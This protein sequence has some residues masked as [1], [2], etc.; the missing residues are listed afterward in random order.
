MKKLKKY[1][2]KQKKILEKMMKKLFGFDFVQA[3]K[4]ESE[5]Q[6]ELEKEFHKQIDLI[7]WGKIKESPT[8]PKKYAKYKTLKVFIDTYLNIQKIYTFTNDYEGEING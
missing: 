1:C 6:M 3:I 7:E 5:I 4:T 8:A 2:D